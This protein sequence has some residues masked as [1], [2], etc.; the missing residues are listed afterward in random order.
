MRRTR[1]AS[2]LAIVTAAAL[3]ACSPRLTVL[4]EDLRRAND[5][6][7]AELSRIQF[8]LSQDLVLSR[9]RKSGSTSIVQGQVRVK[10]GR[11]VEELVFARG[12]PGVVLFQTP[13]GNLA[14]GFDE[15]RDDRFL[16]FGPNPSRG[17]DY[18]LLGRSAGRYGAK[19]T[20]ADKEWDV[21][22][23]SAGVRLL[24]NLKRSG[25]T[26]RKTESVGG[27]RI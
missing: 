1:L 9:E 25:S 15:R 10:D 5:W 20:Y 8:Y 6:T 4:D 7:E 27:R 2:V 11:N 21:S 14:I 17:G 18:V 16:V 19:V 12:T 24:L 3:A 22:N 23:A 13:E 26:R